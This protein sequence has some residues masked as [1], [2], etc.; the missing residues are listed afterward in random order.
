MKTHLSKPAITAWLKNRADELGFSTCGIAP[1]GLLENEAAHLEK[2]LKAGMHGEMAYMENYF[3]KRTDPRKLLDGAK[4]VIVF[5]FNY[6]PKKTLPEDDNYILSKYAYGEDYHFVIKDK[7]Y[8]LIAELKEV[9][10]DINA[11]PFVDSA[12]VLE[13]AWAEK[14]GL[15]WVGKNAN[16]FVLFYFRNHYRS[17]TGLR[18]A[19]QQRFLWR[20]PPVS[21]CLPHTSHRCS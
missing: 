7:L 17:G 10:G 12:P 1:A 2:W 4:S 13:R 11:R 21:R 18:P 15:G 14:A 19:P 8:Q 20:L 6:F 5:L 9:A 16:L 3:D